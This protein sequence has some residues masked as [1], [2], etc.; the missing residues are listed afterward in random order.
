LNEI[1][2]EIVG[3]VGDVRHASVKEPPSP[4]FYQP[5]SQ[6][7]TSLMCLIVRT[8]TDLSTTAAAVV[9]AARTLDPRQPVERVSTLDGIVADTTADD[10]FYAAVT[11]AFSAIGLALAVAGLLGAARRAMA[12]RKKE[13]AIRLALGAPPERL[14]K[15]TLL[16]EM[17]PVFVGG[18]V[19]LVGAFWLSRLLERFLFEVSPLDPWAYGLA[20]ALL[21]GVAA[22]GCYFPARGVM[23]IEPQEVLRAD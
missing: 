18:A 13:L 11:A 3:V 22:I 5:R 12:E 7:P 6:K 21:V 9:K 8:R 16:Q 23:S 4:A 10:R 14:V 20:G 15:L 19:G 2:P 17:R 1:K